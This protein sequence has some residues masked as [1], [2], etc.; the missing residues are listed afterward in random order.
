MK[1]AQNEFLN[2]LKYAEGETSQKQVA[3][4]AIKKQLFKILN[5]SKLQKGESRD[6][7]QTAEQIANNLGLQENKARIIQYITYLFNSGNY[8]F[9]IDESGNIRAN[10]SRI[11]MLQKAEDQR[12]KEDAEKILQG[13]VQK[14]KEYARQLEHKKT[15][16]TLYTLE[17]QF[18]KEELEKYGD[19]IKIAIFAV[20]EQKNQEK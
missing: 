10:Y 9:D 11:Y 16:V 14:A 19:W 17:N 18:S 6:I 13:F 3:K 4:E 2:G 15:K 12:G 20:V 7:D 1:K 8:E 5:D